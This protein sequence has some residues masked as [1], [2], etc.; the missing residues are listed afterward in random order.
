[1]INMIEIPFLDSLSAQATTGITCA[2]TLCLLIDT[3][4]CLL[5]FFKPMSIVFTPLRVKV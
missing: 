4:M 1:M 3:K 5:H 2:V